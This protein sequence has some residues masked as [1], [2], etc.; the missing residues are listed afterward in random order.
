MNAGEKH[1]Y[2]GP[3]L[4]RVLGLTP[5]SS[6]QKFGAD[7]RKV[8]LSPKELAALDADHL[9]ITFDKRVILQ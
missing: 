3:V 2:T 8:I 5:P 7:V 4:Y 9:F 1:G 6:V